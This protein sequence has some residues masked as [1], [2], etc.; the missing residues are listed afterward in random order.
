MR[1][2][3]F[4][5]EMKIRCVGVAPEKNY[6]KNVTYQTLF[7]INQTISNQNLKE[8]KKS[9]QTLLYYNHYCIKNQV[10]V[11]ILKFIYKKIKNKQTK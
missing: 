3:I 5:N 6:K 1:S 2:K 8:H 11:T 4:C 9:R 10:Q 7:F